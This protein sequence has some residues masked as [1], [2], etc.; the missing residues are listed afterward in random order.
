MPGSAT[1]VVDPTSDEALYRECSG[2]DGPVAGRIPEEP[3]EEVV[4]HAEPAEPR[5]EARYPLFREVDLAEVEGLRGLAWTHLLDG[6]DG[7]SDAADVTHPRHG[8]LLGT[9]PRQAST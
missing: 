3:R 4:E 2:T 8:V 7:R 6:P 5:A 1:T 9:A